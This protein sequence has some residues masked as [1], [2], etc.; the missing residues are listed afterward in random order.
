MFKKILCLILI[1]IEEFTS[2]SID[3]LRNNR[4]IYLTRFTSNSMDNLS[5]LVY[6]NRC[7]YLLRNR[8]IKNNSII[9]LRTSNTK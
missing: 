1:I 8:T 4:C 9:Q 7:N 3:N 5:N 2:N 6:N